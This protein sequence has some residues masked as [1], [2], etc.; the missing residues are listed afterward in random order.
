[1][2]GKEKQ[3]QETEEMGCEEGDANGGG[4]TPRKEQISELL[5]RKK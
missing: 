2:K 3:R 5:W 1:M 4:R